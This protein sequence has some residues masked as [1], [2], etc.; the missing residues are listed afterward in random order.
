MRFGHI[1]FPRRLHGMQDFHLV[2]VWRVGSAGYARQ[3]AVLAATCTSMLRAGSVDRCQRGSLV[4]G[5]SNRWCT[6]VNHHSSLIEVLQIWTAHIFWTWYFYFCML[7]VAD[8]GTGACVLDFIF[9]P[10]FW[11]TEQQKWVMADN[12]QLHDTW[13]SKDKFWFWCLVLTVHISTSLIQ[14]SPRK[15]MKIHELPVVFQLLHG[16][17]G[18]LKYNTQLTEIARF[19]MYLKSS[20][21]CPI[22]R[23]GQ[24]SCDC[25]SLFPWRC[26]LVI[27]SCVFPGQG[28][29]HSMGR[30]LS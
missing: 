14:H 12:M 17:A 9:C 8:L 20:F 19:Q 21:G 29:F 30:H 1:S 25:T 11:F 27:R 16:T 28:G 10:W 2:G 15:S 7:P 26:L 13:R 24:L 4:Q 18:L 5:I 23:K 3:R 22:P 6:C